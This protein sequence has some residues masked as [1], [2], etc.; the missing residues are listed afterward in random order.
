VVFA[1]TALLVAAADQLTKTL[2]I[3]SYP[4]GQPIFE[5][6]FFRIVHISNTGAAFGLFQNQSF[7]LT[8]VALIGI[9][10][11]LFYTFYV[12]R[13]FPYLESWLSRVALGLILGGTVGNLIDRLRL[14]HVTDFIDVGIWPSFNIADPALV[15]GTIIFAYSLLFLTRAKSADSSE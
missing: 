3:R 4:E 9:V 1:L 15:V 7:V 6:G 14:G 10:A 2:W 8:I 12:Y 13:R 11:I 5:A